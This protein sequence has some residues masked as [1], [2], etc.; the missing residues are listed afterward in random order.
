MHYHHV[1][2][3]QRWV[4]RLPRRY[5]DMTTVT[6][7]FLYS[8]VQN[9]FVNCAYVAEFGAFEQVDLVPPYIDLDLKFNRTFVHIKRHILNCFLEMCFAH[10]HLANQIMTTIAGKQ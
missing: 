6:R 8:P 4:A 9:S 10:I 5:A 3:P 2:P 1:P 7:N